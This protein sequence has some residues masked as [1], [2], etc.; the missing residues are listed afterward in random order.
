MKAS[1]QTDYAFRIFIVLQWKPK[2]RIALGEIA[3]T[4]GLSLNHLNKVA[5][6]LVQMGLL[7]SFRGQGGGIELAPEALEFQLGD[8]MKELEGDSEIAPCEGYSNLQPCIIAPSCSLRG[9]FS[10]AKEAF[11]K[12]LNQQTIADLKA[13]PSSKV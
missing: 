9:F 5:Q 7:H 13:K 11:Y 4:F 12:S 10:E 2:E 3:N 1:F 8:L 6:K